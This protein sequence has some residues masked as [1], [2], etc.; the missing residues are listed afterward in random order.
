MGEGFATIARRGFH[1]TCAGRCTRARGPRLH[2]GEPPRHSFG[3][4]DA[5]DGLLAS[6]CASVRLRAPPRVSA[7][8]RA[9]LASEP[10]RVRTGGPSSPLP[11][12]RFPLVC[13]LAACLAL[14]C[15]AQDF[16]PPP[17][18]TAR[19]DA[20]LFAYNVALGAAVGGVGAA[21]R[22]GEG[23]RL[24]RLWR[25]AAGGA[26]GGAV[27]YGGKRLAHRVLSEQ[28]MTAAWPAILVHAA[29][30]SLVEN[31]SRGTP[32][33]PRYLLHTGFVRWEAEP[34][35]LRARVLPFGAIIFG[36]MLAR[37]PL[38]LGR[39][40]A[41]GTPVFVQ[42]GSIERPFGDEPGGAFAGLAVLSTILL[43][44]DR[45]D[46]D[47]YETAAHELVH[48]MQYHEYLRLAAFHAPLS[49]R[50]RR[51]GWVDAA[52][53]YVYLD[54]FLYQ[55]AAY[56]L[57]GGGTRPIPCYFNNPLEYE[58]EAFATRRAVPWCE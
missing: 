1:G 38:D 19:Q 5:R 8:L 23:S 2:R 44:T 12:I 51:V 35:G 41:F 37:R 20:R 47:F 24:A 43:D 29:G 32:L 16:E 39:S 26:A 27:M 14:P 25:G 48:V 10:A 6:P 22:E 4:S 45:A 54:V 52:A 53:R 34:S 15:A 55:S 9:V 40:L 50:F 28:R 56:Y 17:G 42:R 13:A 11:V 21:L 36:A 31:A 33:A 7:R 30:T 46:A 18:E 3:V 57:V 58:A 49:R